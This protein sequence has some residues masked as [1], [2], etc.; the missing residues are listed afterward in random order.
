MLIPK[1]TQ[2]IPAGGSTQVLD[3]PT[4]LDEFT[5]SVILQVT[6]NGNITVEFQPAFDATPAKS[7]QLS[8]G[9]VYYF[10]NQD[11]VDA[12]RIQISKTGSSD[13]LATFFEVVR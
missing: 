12:N 4:V 3:V 8:N 5:E 1:F 13:G 2:N 11:L 7:Y 10:R 6:G 9:R